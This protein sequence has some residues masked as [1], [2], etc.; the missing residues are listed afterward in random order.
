[1]TTK[2][3]MA[4]PI[5]AKIRIDRQVFS[6]AKRRNRIWAYPFARVRSHPPHAWLSSLALRA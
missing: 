5:V 3:E 6:Q 4:E 2:P 1:M